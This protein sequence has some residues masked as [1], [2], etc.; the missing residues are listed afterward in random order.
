VFW[1]QRGE[2]ANTTRFLTDVDALTWVQAEAFAGPVADIALLTDGLEPLALHYASKSVHQP[3][4]AGM[5]QPLIAVH[6]DGEIKQLSAALAKFLT[7]ERVRS[8]TDDDV[9]VLLAS[10]RRAQQPRD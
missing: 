3:F 10:C 9:S 1:P 7:S 8:R 5:F 2:Y 6:D 4:F